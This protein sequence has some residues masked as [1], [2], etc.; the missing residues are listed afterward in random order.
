M[1]VSNERVSDWDWQ[2]KAHAGIVFVSGLVVIALVFS[3]ILTMKAHAAVTTIVIGTATGGRVEID[4]IDP[5]ERAK[6]RE[7][8]AADPKVAGCFR[9]ADWGIKLMTERDAGT[10]KKEHLQQVDAMYEKTKL[11]PEGAIARHIYID[12]GRTVRDIHRSAGYS[13]KGKYRYT[14]ADEVWVREFRWC[15]IDHSE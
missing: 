9:R 13:A 1:K 7:R 11:E 6:F 12:F 3:T 10:T 15:A 4:L 2:N 14:N 5:N 8:F